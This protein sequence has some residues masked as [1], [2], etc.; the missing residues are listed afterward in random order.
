MRACLLRH[1]YPPKTLVPVLPSLERRLLA[2]QTPAASPSHFHLRRHPYFKCVDSTASSNFV[3]AHNLNA[4]PTDSSPSPI[5]SGMSIV[6]SGGC[7]LI[8]MSLCVSA[9]LTYVA[10]AINNYSFLPNGVAQLV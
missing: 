3:L 6:Q 5:H 7:L 8:V 1:E 2:K 10:S 4:W 9:L